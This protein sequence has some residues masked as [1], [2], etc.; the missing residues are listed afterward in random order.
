MYVTGKV[1]AVA[2]HKQDWGGGGN[3]WVFIQ[4]TQLGRQPVYC[5]T[6]S[7]QNAE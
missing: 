4:K 7:N 1:Y 6:A 3:V 5:V 2:Q